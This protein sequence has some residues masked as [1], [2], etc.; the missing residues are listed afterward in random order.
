MIL[1][2]ELFMTYQPQNT[3]TAPPVQPKSKV[4][5]GVLGLF[6]GAFGVHNFYLGFNGRAIIQL[7][8]T[9]LSLGTLS[10]VSGIWALVE[11][12]MILLSKLG[13]PA[14]RDARGIELID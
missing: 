4:V 6:L 12:I 5:A 14:H 3:Y 11:S 2:K 8:L 10:F 9:V 7:L 1:F 13:E